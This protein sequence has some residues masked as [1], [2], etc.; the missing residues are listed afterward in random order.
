MLQVPP[1]VFQPALP[2]AA[3]P[4]AGA[5]AQVVARGAGLHGRRGG[6]L[7][8]ALCHGLWRQP[9]WRQWRVLCDHRGA[10]RLSYTGMCICLWN[11]VNV[12]T[13][14]KRS[15]FTATYVYSA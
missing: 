9:R 8:G 1:P 12:R 11:D 5:R 2:A 13:M 7:P 14:P 3:R 4:A 6:R 15:V 10:P